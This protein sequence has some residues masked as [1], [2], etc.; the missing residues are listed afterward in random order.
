MNRS[1]TSGLIFAGRSRLAS[2]LS[3]D[4]F[5]LLDPLVL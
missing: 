2:L 1:Q 3:S 5:R 4:R